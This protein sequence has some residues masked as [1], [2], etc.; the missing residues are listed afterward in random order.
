ELRT[1]Y[2]HNCVYGRVYETAALMHGPRVLQLLRECDPSWRLIVVGDA[3]MAPW[4]LSS[5]GASWTWEEPSGTS[6][7]GWL[8]ALAQHFGHSVWLN[9]EPELAWH[10]TARM[11]GRVYPMYRLTLDG[12]TAAIQRLLRGA[13]TLRGR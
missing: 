10:G 11:I 2:F 12:L 3:L 7:L 13:A 5:D 6:G 1:Y 4:E 8:L 9:P